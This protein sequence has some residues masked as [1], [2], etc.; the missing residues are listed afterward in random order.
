L[1]ILQ[2]DPDVWFAQGREVDH[3][4]IDLM[5]EARNTARAAKDFAEADRIRDELSE[6]GIVIEDKPEGTSWRVTG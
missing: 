5:V 6:L 1:G 3:T 2:Q 4:E